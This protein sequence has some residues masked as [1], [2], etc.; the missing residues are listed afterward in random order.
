MIPSESPLPY[1]RPLLNPHN[2]APFYCSNVCHFQLQARLAS[3][4][5]DLSSTSDD[6][7]QTG[8]DVTTS[9]T[10]SLVNSPNSTL[11]SV[12]RKSQVISDCMHMH[13]GLKKIFFKK[14]FFFGFLVFCACIVWLISGVIFHSRVSRFPDQTVA[15]LDPSIRKTWRPR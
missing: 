9:A 1:R 3:E 10:V 7:N 4:E 8:G 12:R 2:S 14:N 11:S 13:E 15:P 5:K 6:P